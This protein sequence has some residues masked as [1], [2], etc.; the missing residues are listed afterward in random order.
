MNLQYRR[1]DSSQLLLAMLLKLQRK[2]HALHLIKLLGP[3]T[4]NSLYLQKK[5]KKKWG[6]VDAQ[7]WLF[8]FLLENR[9]IAAWSTTS[10]QRKY[11]G[12]VQIELLK[13]FSCCPCFCLR[14]SLGFGL[15]CFIVLLYI[16]FCAVY[17]NPSCFVAGFVFY[18]DA[19]QRVLCFVTLLHNLL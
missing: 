9:Y 13:L 7:V 16:P 11:G 6:G 4:R 2:T 10:C 5:K 3:H 17:I 1:A 8:L 14:C 19:L 15:A 18:R 12:V